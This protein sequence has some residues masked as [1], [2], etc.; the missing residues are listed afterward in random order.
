M[1]KKEIKCLSL[2]RCET[3]MRNIASDEEVWK[4]CIGK[5]TR[6]EIFCSQ[7]CA[8]NYLDKSQEVSLNSS[9]D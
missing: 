2:M 7:S 1:E 4:N 6:K 9:H 5:K 8:I 3:C